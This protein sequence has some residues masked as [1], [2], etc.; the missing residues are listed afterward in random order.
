MD[1][2]NSRSA[3]IGV[4]LVLLTHSL[5]AQSLGKLCLKPDFI[6]LFQHTPTFQ[7][8][9]EYKLSHKTSIQPTAGFCYGTFY[10]VYKSPDNIEYDAFNLRGFAT[11]L[12]YRYYLQDKDGVM[13]GIYVAPEIGY[14]YVNYQQGRFFRIFT[15]NN[16]N[17]QKLLEYAVNKNTYLYHLKIGY[18][19]KITSRVYLDVFGGI[20]RR[21]ITLKN[22][23][24][25]P[26]DALYAEEVSRGELYWGYKGTKTRF[27][28]TGSVLLGFMF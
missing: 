23:I 20:G 9:A 22:N 16:M 21:I 2:H 5:N 14:K 28:I 6:A 8:R 18:Q 1:K 15:S 13:E 7:I 19:E 27:S 17:Y 3:I 25:L 4:F 24:K 26:D 10:T 11:R 12:E